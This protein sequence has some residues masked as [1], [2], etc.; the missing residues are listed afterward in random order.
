MYLCIYIVELYL[1]SLN[2]MTLTYYLN[3][4]AKQQGVGITKVRQH[5][6]LQL[7]KTEDCLYKWEIGK[8]KPRVPDLKKLKKLLKFYGFEVD[9]L[10]LF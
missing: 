6:A 3:K 7:G 2:K 9:V 8:R 1:K 5:F 4:V 10:K